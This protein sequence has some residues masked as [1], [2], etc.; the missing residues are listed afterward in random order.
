MTYFSF[1]F[2]SYVCAVLV[3][4]SICML[5]FRGHKFDRTAIVSGVAKLQ[6]GCNSLHIWTGGANWRSWRIKPS[7]LAV[8]G[9]SRL[10]VE[11]LPTDCELP[12]F[13]GI[14][15]ALPCRKLS[16]FRMR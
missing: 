14:Q 10:A 15:Q 4:V 3:L 7:S 8:A 12:L 11:G 6:P 1:C 16:V 2:V 13:V 9:C 5:Y